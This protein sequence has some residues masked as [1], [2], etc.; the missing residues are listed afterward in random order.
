M[1]PQPSNSPL[2]NT[3]DAAIFPA[4]AKKGSALQ[5]LA[6][7][8][9]YLKTDQVWEILT[10]AWEEYPLEKIAR[11]FVHHSQVAAAIYECKGGDEFVKQRN[12]LSFGVWRVCQPYWK[13]GSDGYAGLDLT[14]FDER[15]IGVP[16]GVVVHNIHDGV[17]IDS[18]N[19]KSLRYDRPNMEAHDI[20]KYLSYDG[21]KLIAS[22]PDND[23]EVEIDKILY[24]NLPENEQA[25]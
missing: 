11:T 24:D 3:L 2:T 14:F 10:K 5:G 6:N 19:S 7:G 22:A 16:D 9:R 15:D 8:G 18:R 12:G 13:D 21:L 23:E 1:T 17:D 25:R 20:G 4:L